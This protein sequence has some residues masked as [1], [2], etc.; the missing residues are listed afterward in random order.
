MTMSEIFNNQFALQ[1]DGFS[2][3]PPRAYEIG[4]RAL[5]KVDGGI[6]AGELVVEI[7]SGTGNSSIILAISNPHLRRLICIEPSDFINLAAYKLGKTDIELPDEIPTQTRQYIEEQREK[8]LPIVG[9][10]DLVRGRM[11]ELSIA[12]GVVD[13]VYA[14]SSFHWLSF[15]DQSSPVDFEH[16]KASV[17]EIARVLKAGGRFLFDSNGHILN[18]GDEEANN[19]RIN[20]MHFTKH[21]LWEK[22]N[23][24]FYEVLSQRGFEIGD[25]TQTPDRLQQIFNLPILEDILRENDLQLI[26]NSAGGQYLLTLIPYDKERLINSARSGAKMNKFSTPQLKG[27]SE[28]EKGDIV[29]QALQQAIEKNPVA[30]DGDYYETFVTF[31][32][33]KTA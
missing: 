13:R 1:Y 11:P 28:K 14:A 21:P 24:S 19:R 22:F 4:S 18:F 32:A 23:S 26:P 20:D 33:Q 25:I 17:A 16:L 7:G 8:A 15:R 10:V 2:A 30:F 12:T 6:K 27:L 5:V 3:A 31:V 9:K 29:E